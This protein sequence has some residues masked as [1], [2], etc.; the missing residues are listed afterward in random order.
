MSFLKRLFGGHT[1]SSEPNIGKHVSFKSKS[2]AEEVNVQCGDCGH[3]NTISRHTP[4]FGTALICAHCS[5]PL[6]LPVSNPRENHYATPRMVQLFFGY[7]GCSL[8]HA[9]C[10]HCG[11]TN[12]SIVIP[13]QGYHVSFY[14][15][16]KQENPNA[17]FVVNAAC[18]HCK[19]AFV[20]EWD[21]DPR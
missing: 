21:E 10:P 1:T 2:A 16:R 4:P 12:Y 3:S 11:K 8:L 15:N 19:R 7:R 17:A 14:W 20:I 9:S 5:K 6:V 18:P 13:E